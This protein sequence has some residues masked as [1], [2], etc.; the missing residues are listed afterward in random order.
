[1]TDLRDKLKT[2]DKIKIYVDKTRSNEFTGSVFVEDLPSEILSRL[3]VSDETS[4]LEVV[5]EF[6]VEIDDPSEYMAYAMFSDV[7]IFGEDETSVTLDSSHAALDPEDIEKQLND[8][9]DWGDFFADYEAGRADA[10]YDAWKDS[11]YE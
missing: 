3:K 9:I 7:V 11:Q 1:M 5:G 10:A 6:E 8:R 2:Q 4:E